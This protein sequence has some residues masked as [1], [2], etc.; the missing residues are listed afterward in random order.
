MPELKELTAQEE[1]RENKYSPTFLCTPMSYRA[2]NAEINQAIL[3]IIYCK[4]HAKQFNDKITWK[5]LHVSS[6]KSALSVRTVWI[7]VNMLTCSL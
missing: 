1:N 3:A 5:Y 7:N 4:S 6:D 2:K